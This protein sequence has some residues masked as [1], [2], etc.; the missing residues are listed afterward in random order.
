[1]SNIIESK[2]REAPWLGPEAALASRDSGGRDCHVCRT[3]VEK[4][5]LLEIAD[6]AP[7]ISRRASEMEAQ[8]C[9]PRDLVDTSEGL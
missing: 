9:I 8:R 5:L 7:T 6:M 3:S 1:M 4:R 2:K